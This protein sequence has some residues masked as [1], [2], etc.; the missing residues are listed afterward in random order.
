MLKLPA[1]ISQSIYL[2]EYAWNM[3]C[4]NICE[5]VWRVCVKMGNIASNKIYIYVNNKKNQQ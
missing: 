1:I 2:Y 5:E 4:I 3:V